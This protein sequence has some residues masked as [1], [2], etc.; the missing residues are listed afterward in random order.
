MS[1][2]GTLNNIGSG[3]SQAAS[4]DG[5]LL[6]LVSKNDDTKSAPFPTNDP[7]RFKLHSSQQQQQHAASSESSSELKLL[8]RLTLTNSKEEEQWGDDDDFTSTATNEAP[9]LLMKGTSGGSDDVKLLDNNETNENDIEKIDGWTDDKV[10]V[11]ESTQVEEEEFQNNTTVVAD[12]EVM[13]A[14]LMNVTNNG[15]SGDDDDDDEVTIDIAASTT[16]NG[17]NNSTADQLVEN[18]G[19]KASSDSELTAPPSSTTSMLDL[20]SFTQATTLCQDDP[21]FIHPVYN[22]TCVDLVGEDESKCEVDYSEV[23]VVDNSDGVGE[24][25]KMLKVK[26]VCKRS[27]GLCDDDDDIDTVTELEELKLDEEEM[28]QLLKDSS[29]QGTTNETMVVDEEGVQ[30]EEEEDESGDENVD[31]KNAS[32]ID[33][34]EEEELAVKMADE[35]DAFIPDEEVVEVAVGGEGGIEEDLDSTG[36]GDEVKEEDNE[37]EA[38]LVTDENDDQQLEEETESKAEIALDEG[39]DD[40]EMAEKLEEEMEEALDEELVQPKEEGEEIEAASETED[41]S[42]LCQDDPE[43]EYKGYEGFNCAYIKEKK[44]DKCDKKHQGVKVGLSSCPV[45]CDMVDECMAL[46]KQTNAVVVSSA[47]ETTTEKSAEAIADEQV[48]EDNSDDSAMEQKDDL[49]LEKEMESEL[50]TALEQGTVD[51]ETAE[52]LD[53]EMLEALEE[54]VG[55]V[56]EKELEEELGLDGQEVSDDLSKEKMATEVDDGNNLATI[57]SSFTEDA[58]SV[59]ANITI[60]EDDSS[61]CQDD[62]DFKFKGYEGFNC[63]YIKENKPEK[64]NKMFD[65]EKVGVVSCPVSCGMVDECIALQES[66]VDAALENVLENNETLS[67]TTSEEDAVLTNTTAKEIADEGTENT[68]ALEGT[69]DDEDSDDT[70]AQLVEG[71]EDTQVDAAGNTTEVVTSKEEAVVTEQTDTETEDDGSEELLDEQNT[72]YSEEDSN[73][74][75]ETTVLCQDDPDFK[76]KGYE[77]FNCEYI[78]E[79]KPEKCNKLHDGEKVGV[80]SCPVSC[81]MVDECMALQDSKVGAAL[82][83]ALDNNETLSNTTSEEDA[84]VTNTTAKEIADEGTENTD[85]LEG[86]EDDEASDDTNDQLLV[87]G[88]EDTQVGAVLNTTEVVTSET[89]TETSEELLKEQNTTSVDYS[90]AT[91]IPSETQQVDD[92]MEEYQILNDQELEQE[93]EVKLEKALEDGELDEE[94]AQELEYEME[95]AIEEGVGKIF[96]AEL[97]KELRCKDDPDFA[98]VDEDG[99]LRNC[100]WVRPNQRCDS[101]HEYSGKVIGT[102]FCPETCGMEYE[103]E[104]VTA[105]NS[106]L[107]APED[108]T[109]GT[110]GDDSFE[111]TPKG[112]KSMADEI[113]IKSEFENGN[114]YGSENV[115]PFSGGDTE[116]GSFTNQN[117]YNQEPNS[118]VGYSQPTNGVDNWQGYGGE[119]QEEGGSF[120]NNPPPIDYDENWLEDDSGFPFGFLILL[121]LG[122]G[123]FIFRKSQSSR[124]QENSR[125]GYQRVGGR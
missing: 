110:E 1:L 76:F 47:D 106:T 66:K 8:R 104:K 41:E 28:E 83:H 13:A 39:T 26:D 112:T 34:V 96:E 20:S 33:T 27:C 85:A 31:K 94:E 70:K 74:T 37:E 122:V 40:E 11:E 86:T 88:S 102:F 101:V 77:D 105:A 52:I 22:Q 98:I 90:Q 29:K 53:E 79:N 93:I 65:G 35:D 30:E 100:S 123:F 124:L 24:G 21:T 61:V 2:R 64:C 3:S 121:F 55:G 107:Q 45:S 75:D 25:E 81:D 73:E 103:C 60:S 6:K 78:K 7:L 109:S 42:V 56:F 10:V 108:K 92:E 18:E 23:R 36:T 117:E 97:D 57:D 91:T 84:V 48:S 50:E 5:K 16:N 19:M 14:S 125:G 15:G 38:V 32:G 119:N 114:V 4:S 99:Q 67:N 62:P 63:E 9:L 80:V 118:N 54:G 51:E 71:S 115:R 120:D 17:N 72:A 116:A 43:F 87:E 95:E 49:Q 69:E 68:D 111:A 113:E 44:P 82:E 12:E 59:V 46:Q 58:S 89:E